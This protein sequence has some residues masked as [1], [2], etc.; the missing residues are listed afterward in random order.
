MANSLVNFKDLTEK[1]TFANKEFE[2]DLI[3]LKKIFYDTI[4]KS[5]NFQ[6]ELKKLSSANKNERDFTEAILKAV[7]VQHNFFQS[8]GNNRQMS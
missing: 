3:L 7:D 6:R 2:H 5:I 1:R 8:D 4:E